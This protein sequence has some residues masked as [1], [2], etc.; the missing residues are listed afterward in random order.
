MLN[1]FYTPFQIY[2]CVMELCFTSLVLH[3]SSVQL[4]GKLIF[5]Y[6]GWLPIKQA[7]LKSTQRVPHMI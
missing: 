3:Q 7:K 1:I 2:D 4:Q 6:A 5:Q